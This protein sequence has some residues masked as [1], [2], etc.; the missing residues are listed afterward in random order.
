MD[1]AKPKKICNYMGVRG[2]QAGIVCGRTIKTN[3]DYCCEHAR[4][5]K[6]RNDIITANRARRNENGVVT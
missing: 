4:L 3:K 1:D 5:V 2:N 6:R